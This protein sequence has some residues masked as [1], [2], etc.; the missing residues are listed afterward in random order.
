MVKYEYLEE[1]KWLPFDESFL[2]ESVFVM[3]KLKQRQPGYTNPTWHKSQL[4]NTSED[5]EFINRLAWEDSV[6]RYI[7]H[8]DGYGLVNYVLI[9]SKGEVLMKNFDAKVN[10][11]ENKF[12]HINSDSLKL[13]HLVLTNEA[14]A[15]PNMYYFFDG[16]DFEEI[17]SKVKQAVQKKNINPPMNFNKNRGLK[18][19]PT[20]EE[21]ELENGII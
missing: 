17:N 19:Q 7:G 10:V 18:N 5:R 1:K 20:K 16:K 8:I 12:I 14:K 13:N 11:D 9:N 4:F 2:K 3:W 15:N 21:N 6:S